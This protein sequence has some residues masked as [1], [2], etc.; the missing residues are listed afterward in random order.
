MTHVKDIRDVFAHAVF[1]Y[2]VK[3]F[4]VLMAKTLT[5]SECTRCCSVLLLIKQHEMTR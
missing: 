1:A 5:V 2:I 3:E 4:R